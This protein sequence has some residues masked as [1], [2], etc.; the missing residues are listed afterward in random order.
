M[1]PPPPL[2]MLPVPGPS[3]RASQRTSSSKRSASS[4]PPDP[5]PRPSSPQPLLAEPEDEL[6]NDDAINFFMESNPSDE[7]KLAALRKLFKALFPDSWDIKKLLHE[8]MCDSLLDDNSVLTRRIVA[9]VNEV[10]LQQDH[11]QSTVDELKSSLR[12][13]EKINSDP[14]L[15]T[16]PV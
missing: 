6:I 8:F 16:T 3:T 14:N 4:P 13:Q 2:N 7:Q 9:E 15:S 11:L 5:R 1:M 10:Q 12:Q